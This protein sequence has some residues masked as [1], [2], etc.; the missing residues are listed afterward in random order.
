ML[1]LDLSHDERALLV[2][3]GHHVA[4]AMWQ[5]LGASDPTFQA[6]MHDRAE[7]VCEDG[8]ALLQD[9]GVFHADR[10]SSYRFAMP[11]D[12][13]R[14]HLRGLVP[15]TSYNLDQIIGVF[16]WALHDLGEISTKKDPFDVPGHLQQA[17]WGFVTLGLAERGADGFTWTDKIAPIMIAEFFWTDDGESVE[18]LDKAAADTL[19]EDMWTA[20]PV[21]RRH[22]L[23]RRVTRMSNL[24][25]FT[26][27]F[28]RWDGQG[29]TLRD[30]RKGAHLV[31]P[32]GYRE[33]AKTLVGKLRDTRRRHP[34]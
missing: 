15:Q 27:L 25:L 32:H 8:C 11:L 20:L 17:M 19:A 10:P 7:S 3:L 28:R 9:L 16:L 18:S 1:T 13:V 26:H 23:A 24:D 29:F 12:H 21:W 5:R 2:E 33:V 30:H 34:F 4:R 6:V 31:L 22:V 14:D